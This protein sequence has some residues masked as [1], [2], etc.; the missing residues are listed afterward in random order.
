MA[1][2]GESSIN[3]NLAKRKLLDNYVE[4]MGVFVDSGDQLAM[5]DSF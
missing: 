5:V 4:I 1:C 2:S 3:E